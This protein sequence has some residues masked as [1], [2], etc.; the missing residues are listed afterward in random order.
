[1][2]NSQLPKFIALHFVAGDIPQAGAR[3]S[4]ILQTCARKRIF[5][6]PIF[7]SFVASWIGETRIGETWIME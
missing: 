7:L 2:V 1:M 5:V 3:Q 4:A 6:S